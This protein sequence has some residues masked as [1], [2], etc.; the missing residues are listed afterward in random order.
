[1]VSTVVGQN[2]ASRPFRLDELRTPPGFEV[3]VYARVSGS[4]R[5]MTIGPNGVLYVAS[6]GN[7]IVAIPEAGRV[8]TVRGGLSGPHSV[9][10]RGND[11]YVGVNDGVVRFSNAVTED[12]VIRNA[13]ERVVTFTVP[14]GTP[15]QHSTRT[16]YFGPDGKL[17]LTAGSTCNFC[18]EQDPRRAAMTRYEAD[19]SGETLFARGLRNTVGFAFHPVTGE[20]WGVDNGGDGLGDDDPPEEINIIRENQDHGWP[21]CRGNRRGVNWGLQARPGRCGETEP[22][23]FEIPA[24]S[25]PLAISFYSGDMLPASWRNDALV[26]LHGSW[27]RSGPSGFKVVRVR[28]ADGRATASQDLL[29]GF[30]DSSTRTRSGRPVHPISGSDGAVYVSDDATGNIYRIAYTGPRINP[31]GIVRVAPRI[32]ELYGSRLVN[33][34]AEFAVYANGVQVELLYAGAG[35]ANFVLPENLAGDVTI[36]VKNEKAVDEILIRVE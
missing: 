23:E 7:S 2:V 29:W 27:N 8:V 19:G 10:F 26:G 32:Y 13:P 5:L 34:P 15:N 16:A 22:P 31:G 20:I 14:P 21:D 30:F 9:T 36:A 12:L 1:M 11:L 3:S 35:Q 4:P 25:A 17:Y 28:A 6:R 33:D 24:H 18:V